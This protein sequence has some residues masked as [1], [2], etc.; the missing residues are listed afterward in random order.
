M[1]QLSFEPALDPYHTMF[2][3]LRLLPIVR[4]IGRLE[5]EHV[6]ILDFFLVFPFK[7]PELRLKQEHRRFRALGNRYAV[8]KP[9]AEQPESS[10]LIKRMAPISDAAF[11]SLAAKGFI[12]G[13]DYDAG[14]VKPVEKWIPDE[15]S[16]KIEA[17]NSDQQDLMDFLGTLASE[18]DLGGENGL[19]H[20][21]GLMEH[22]YDAV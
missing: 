4:P 7:L 1:V 21:S 2:R 12:D 6:R 13:S 10:L 5:R 15:L 17:A 16:G 8:Q 18:Y 14:W 22:R 19:K 3:G 11:Q 9:Y 20:R